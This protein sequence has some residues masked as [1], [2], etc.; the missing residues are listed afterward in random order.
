M[1][2][3]KSE[4][5]NPKQILIKQLINFP[6]KIIHLNFGFGYCLVRQEAWRIGA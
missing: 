5:R 2:N 6:N 4:I 3:S 1:T